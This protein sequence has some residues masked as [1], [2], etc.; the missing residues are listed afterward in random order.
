M[1]RPA[2][3]GHQPLRGIE[4]GGGL[5]VPTLRDCHARSIRAVS[6]DTRRLASK[7]RKEGLS[8]EEMSGGTFTISNLGMFGIDHFEAIINPPQAA[9]LAVGAALERPVVRSG[10]VVPGTTMSCTLS[11]DHRVIDGAMAA[12]FL[13]TLQYVLE[14]PAICLV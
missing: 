9:I 12:E 3:T 1:R 6:E 2:K 11:C 5:V 4:Q 14:H 7:A 10:Q 13:Q 8:L